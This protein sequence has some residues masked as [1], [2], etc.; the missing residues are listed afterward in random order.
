[1]SSE[2]K[3]PSEVEFASFLVYNPR[4]SEFPSDV[5]AHSRKVCNAVKKETAQWAMKHRLAERMRA[6][7]G[8]EIRLRFLPEHATL[9]PM[10]GHAPLKDP[11]S[12]W[13]ARELC[14]AF[15]GAQLGARW[16]P[17]LERIVAVPKAAFSASVE[18]PSAEEHYQALRARGDL[19]AGSLI[20]VVGDV[21]T[22]GSTLLA[23]IAR[24]RE[25]CPQARVCG[26]ALVRTMSDEPIAR[27]KEPCIGKIK[28]GPRGTLRRP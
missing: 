12:H 10:P 28:Y 23:G 5:S 24:L 19:A 13:A 14:E 8:E 2:P 18:R 16:L 1:M 27:V 4:P 17:L 3:L 25:A 26:F 7:L 15:V 6:E 21:V 22:R 9:V 11:K 20:T